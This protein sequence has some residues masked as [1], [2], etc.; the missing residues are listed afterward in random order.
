MSAEI[1]YLAGTFDD[2]P[3]GDPADRIIAATAIQLRSRLVTADDR[4][5]QSR[6]VDTVW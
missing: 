6:R 2:M 5:R 3:P 4:L 1:A